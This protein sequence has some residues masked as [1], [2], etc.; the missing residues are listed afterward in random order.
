MSHWQKKGHVKSQANVGVLYFMGQQ[1][2][3]AFYWLQKA[4][5][6]GDTTAQTTLGDMYRGGVKGAEGVYPK[7][8]VAKAR[9]WY[10]KAAKQGF[11]PAI[12]KLETLGNK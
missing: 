2:R 11:K 4:A 12:E 9:Y 6:K 7:K 5:N 10:Q 8:D 3:K 1:N